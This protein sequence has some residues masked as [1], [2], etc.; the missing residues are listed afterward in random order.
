MEKQKNIQIEV[1]R[2]IAMF[3]IVLGHAFTHGNA[4]ESIRGGGQS[5]IILQQRLKPFQFQEQT[6]SF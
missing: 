2:I 3:M 5:T 6:F 1:V 4:T